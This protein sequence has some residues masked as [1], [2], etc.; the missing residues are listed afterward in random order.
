MKGM[1]IEQRFPGATTCIV[2]GGLGPV[3]DADLSGFRSVLWYADEADPASVPG[4]DPGSVQTAK[5]SGVRTAD[6]AQTVDTFVARDPRHLPTLFVTE[7]V[8]SHAANAHEV[9]LR[10]VHASLETHH[11]ARVTRQKDG[12]L[13]QRHLL[14]NLPAYAARR[15]P[16]SW[17]GALTGVPAFVTGAGPSLDASVRRLAEESARGVVIAADSALRALARHGVRADL[18]VSIDVSKVPDKC[19]P[20]GHEPDRVVLSSVSPPAWLQALDAGRHYFV[21]NRQ[22]TLDW[23]EGLGITRTG[24]GATESCGTTGLE[25]AVFLGCRPIYLFGMDL[26]LD[27]KSPQMRNSAS[28][29]PALYAKSGFN[30][31]LKMPRVPANDGG[32]VPTHLYGDWCALNERLAQWPAGLVVNVNDRGAQLV[33]TVLVHPERFALEAVPGAKRPLLAS[34]GAPAS[35]DAATLEASLGAVARMG[36]RGRAAV[37]GL[38][39]ALLE[40]G[41]AAASAALRALFTNPDFARM[42]GAFSLK[43]IPH[44]A[45][46]VEGTTPFWKEL[47]D[48]AEELCGLAAAVRA[49]S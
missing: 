2:V 40:G 31:L 37:P 20:A 29:D 42:M 45:P 3:T 41:P 13:W 7:A 25:L 15:I 1:L 19:L 23:L 32:E 38:R 16:A 34:L 14:R 12:F 18:A 8:L 21:S 28:A 17:A 6:V 39:K 47:V 48:E 27:P 26:A 46:P 36:E 22:V 11:R 49:R 9:V 4:A 10:Q 5:V 30:P 44:L 43:V 35:P 33:N 24:V